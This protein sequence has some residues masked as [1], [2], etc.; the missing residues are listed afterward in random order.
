LATARD[1]TPIDWPPGVLIGKTAEQ[2]GINAYQIEFFSP[3]EYSI[4]E[5]MKG[6]E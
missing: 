5:L 2:S 1:C 6:L 4:Q 3:N